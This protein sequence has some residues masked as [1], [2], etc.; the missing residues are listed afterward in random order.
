M[1]SLFGTVFM[2]VVCGACAHCA[3]LS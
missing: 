1:S 2:T 3:E